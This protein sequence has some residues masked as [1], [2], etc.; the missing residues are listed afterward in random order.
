MVVWLAAAGTSWAEVMTFHD[1]VSPTASYQ[2][3]QDVMLIHP[4]WSGTS[5]YTSVENSIDSSPLNERTLMAWDISAIPTNAT[6]NSASLVLQLSNGTSGNFFLQQVLRPWVHNQATWMEAQ[7]GTPW[8]VP[9]VDGSS[10]RGM[11][12]LATI[13]GASGSRTY[14]LNAAGIAV[15]QGWVT[16]PATNHGFIFL[17]LLMNKDGMQ[18]LHAD[19]ATVSQRPRLNI[20]YNG[21]TSISFLNG[22]FPDA[23]YA[24]NVDTKIL[25]APAAN[26]NAN[27]FDLSIGLEPEAKAL[28]RFDL[29]PLPAG[30]RV[31][32]ASLSLSIADQAPTATYSIVAMLRAWSET[33]ATWSTQDGFV[34]WDIPGAEG[35]ADRTTSPFASATFLVGPAKLDLNAQGVQWVDDWVHGVR[36]NQGFAVVG[37][38]GDNIAIYRRE[39]PNPANR[40]ALTLTYFL[41]AVVRDG[42][43]ELVDGGP[44]LGAGGEGKGYQTFKVGCGCRSTDASDLALVA[45]LLWW[46]RARSRPRKD[47]KNPDPSMVA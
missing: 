11:T 34:A 23:L 15:I 45:L 35:P 32:A 43:P 24:G 19:A 28:L 3:T 25:N 7:S 2:G 46:M 1:G 36:P 42:G 33:G 18:F 26:T 10:D 31:T 17:D 40:P 6:V 8:E 27:G 30:A 9:G 12:S 44:E 39:D 22:Q 20:T 4:A 38:N 29:S 37:A 5:N 47:G 14:N 21:A 41:E 16:N 13:N